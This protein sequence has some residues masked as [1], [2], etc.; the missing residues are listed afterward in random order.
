VRRQR[1]RVVILIA[2]AA[3]FPVTFY[4][5]S[6]A[7]V[8]MGASEGIVTGSFVVFGG[9]FVSGLAFGRAF[10]GWLCPAGAIGEGVGRLRDRRIRRRWVSRIKYGIWLPWLGLIATLAVRSGGLT[11]V[12]VTYQTWHGISVGSWNALVVL[13]IVVSLVAALALT[14]G[15]RGF[16]HTVCWIA[17]FTIVGRAVRDR[18]RLPG[19][20]LLPKPDRCVSCGTCTHGCPM[21]LD[22]RSM[23]RERSMTNAECVL[24]ARCVDRCPKGAIELR[25]A[26]FGADGV[27]GTPAVER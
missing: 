17:P 7:V 5:L 21:S 4:Y 13:T 15:R 18:L 24:C 26:R 23:V 14:V 8:L 12:E 10:C 11:R 16:C 22:V 6:P 3:L 9:L 25:F 20:R 2:S 27:R 1:I 19:L